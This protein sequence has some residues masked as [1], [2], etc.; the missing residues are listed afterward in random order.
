MGRGA[1]SRLQG[2]T[3]DRAIRHYGLQHDN[4]RHA[5]LWHHIHG[6]TLWILTVVLLSVQGISRCQI[7]ALSLLSLDVDG[8]FSDYTRRL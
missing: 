1:L 4:R 8:T 5:D 2:C 7:I 6:R 3:T